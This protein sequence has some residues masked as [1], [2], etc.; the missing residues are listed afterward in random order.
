M[1]GVTVH[2]I[3]NLKT[4][5]LYFNSERERRKYLQDAGLG[6]CGTVNNS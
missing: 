6:S 4:F 1:D 5:N 3:P 2:Y